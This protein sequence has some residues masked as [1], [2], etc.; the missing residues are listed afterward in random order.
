MVEALAVFTVVMIRSMFST[1]LFWHPPLPF[2]LIV[3]YA[4]FLRRRSM[5]DSFAPQDEELAS[6]WADSMIQEARQ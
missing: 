1:T 5:Q 4:E 2:L 3:G 6:D